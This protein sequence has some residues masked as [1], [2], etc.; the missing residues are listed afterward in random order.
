MFIHWA[1]PYERRVDKV[2]ALQALRIWFPDHL[3][4]LLNVTLKNEI[5]QHHI[6]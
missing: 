1:L 2:K 5:F 4:K 3:S 6:I